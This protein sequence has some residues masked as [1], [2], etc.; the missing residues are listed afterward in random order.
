MRFPFF[1]QEEQDQLIVIEKKMA[2]ETRGF[3][4]WVQ[5]VRKGFAHNLYGQ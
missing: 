2:R 4:Y 3:G 5:L 1:H